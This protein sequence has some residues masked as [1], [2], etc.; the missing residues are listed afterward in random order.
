[1]KKALMAIPLAFGIAASADAGIIDWFKQF[2]T[3]KNELRSRIVSQSPVNYESSVEYVKAQQY[4]KALDAFIA[5]WENEPKN[6]ER[7]KSAGEWLTSKLWIY[8][9]QNN[10]LAKETE[11]EVARIYCQRAEGMSKVNPKRIEYLDKARTH[12]NLAIDNESETNEALERL[13]K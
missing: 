13:I 4:Q 1:M 12:L 11:L 7:S 2:F 9:V 6:S 3:G 8:I 10:P 5:T